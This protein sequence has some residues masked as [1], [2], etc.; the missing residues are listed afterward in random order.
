[1][2]LRRVL[3]RAS[4]ALA[5]L[6]VGLAG[7]SYAAAWWF[8]RG[9]GL[10]HE[11]DRLTRVADVRPGMT[12]AE[13]GAGSGRLAARM[14]RRVGES[15]RVYATEI[16]PF[17]IERIGQV[18][19][20]RGV[21]NVSRIL[22]GDRDTGLPPACCEVIYM[23]RVYHHLKDP[24]AINSGLYAALRPGG[25]LV[26]IDFLTPGWLPL[27][28]HGVDPSA[29]KSQVSAAGFRFD[30]ALD[31]WSLLDYCLVFRKPDR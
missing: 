1:M 30:R 9:P 22:A 15:G 17:L 2:T 14:A 4:L 16:S 20:A 18:A 3:F 11:A 13:I 12:L 10:E 8:Q 23:R 26:V 25:R 6:A 27:R 28:R 5:G 24:P 31:R 21:T 19:A 7:A 29:V